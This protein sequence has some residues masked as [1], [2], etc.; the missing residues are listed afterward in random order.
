MTGSMDEWMEDGINRTAPDGIVQAK[1]WQNSSAVEVGSIFGSILKPVRFNLAPIR[2]NP[3]QR[4]LEKSTLK[5][6]EAMHHPF[7]L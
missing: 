3:I 1:V 6:A 2:L 7:F 5:T 4:T